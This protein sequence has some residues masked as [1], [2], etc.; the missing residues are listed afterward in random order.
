MCRESEE[1]KGDVIGDL[2]FKYLP[3][4]GEETVFRPGTEIAPVDGRLDVRLLRYKLEAFFEAEQAAVHAAED[5]AC[6]Q[7][8]CAG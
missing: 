7:V 8:A 5:A 1:C 3:R 6:H 4:D 2:L